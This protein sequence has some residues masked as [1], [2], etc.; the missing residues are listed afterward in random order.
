MKLRSDLNP[1]TV[2]WAPWLSPR[3]RQRGHADCCLQRARFHAIV[4]AFREGDLE[5]GALLERLDVFE[6]VIVRRDRHAEVIRPDHFDAEGVND[7]Q[8]FEV[9]EPHHLSS[10][11]GPSR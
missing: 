5:R 8:A 6:Y 4:L 10:L 11:D 3:P 7:F 1:R 2:A 9:G